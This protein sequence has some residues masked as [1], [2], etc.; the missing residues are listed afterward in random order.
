MAEAYPTKSAEELA[1]WYVRSSYQSFVESEGAPLYQGSAIEDL[2]ALEL[3][4][5]ER[6]GGKVAYTR[7]A[8]QE[9]MSLQIVEIPPGGQLK[10]EHHMYDATMLVISGIGVTN[11]W[12]TGERPH[13]VEWHEGSL[14]AIPL[15]AWHQ[16]FNASGSEPC[17]FVVGSN[18]AQMINHYHN[19]D[20]IFNNP[21]VFRD[22]YSAERDDYYTNQPTHWALRL[23]ETNFIPDVRT[24]AVDAW[25]EKGLRTGIAR[26][27]MAS[28]SLGLHILDVGE[29][30]YATAHRH[31]A[32]A[33][34]ICTG[35]TGYELMYFEEEANDPRRVPL[36][37]YGVIAP[38]TGEFH[39]HF[40]TGKGPMRQIAF[41]S[42]GAR[43]GTGSM[44]NPRGAS[45][46]TDPYGTGFQI[47]YENEAPGIREAYY[48]ELERNGI[49]LRL[50]PVKQGA[51]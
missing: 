7:L 2:N 34:V 43:Y 11:I 49:E 10:P 23:W 35:G 36:R 14:L 20:F 32:G 13:T 39:Q 6:R 33:H 37:P 4:D 26:L 9:V 18:M 48:A 21:Y 15:N 51:S 22:R 40:N 47:D 31:A 1:R 50:P 19:L 17:R 30:T 12:Q 41:R 24:F 27:S 38:K 28:T 44:Y 46:T 8:D 3:T 16:E 25:Q 42:S 45:Q 29:G 5:W